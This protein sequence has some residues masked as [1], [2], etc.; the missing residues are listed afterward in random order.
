MSILFIA[1][2]EK[3]K[4]ENQMQK[5]DVDKKENEG[6]IIWKHIPFSNY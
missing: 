6:Q 5:N 4:E 1:F 2:K 3:N